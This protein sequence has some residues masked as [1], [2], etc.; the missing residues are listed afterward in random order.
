MTQF[1][2]QQS[3]A[4]F[5]ARFTTLGFVLFSSVNLHQNMLGNLGK[6]GLTLNDIRMELGLPNLAGGNATYI[7][8]TNFPPPRREGIV[9]WHVSSYP[10]TP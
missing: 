8:V 9:V 7:V 2:V 4:S 1:A 3:E 5:E 6:Y 10:E